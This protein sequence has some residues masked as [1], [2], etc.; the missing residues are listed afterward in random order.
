MA[1]I[2]MAIKNGVVTQELSDLHNKLVQERDVKFASKFKDLKV[3]K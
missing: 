2:E 3:D 1:D